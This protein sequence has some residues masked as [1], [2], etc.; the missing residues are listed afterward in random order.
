M[1]LLKLNVNN[2]IYY[3]VKQIIYFIQCIYVL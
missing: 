3:V 1:R 2:E